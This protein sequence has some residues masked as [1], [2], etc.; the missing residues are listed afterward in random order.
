[1]SAVVVRPV[2]TRAERRAFLA[3][4]WRI[5]RDDPLWVPPLL[6]D[7]ADRIDPRKGIFFKRGEAEFF[8]AWRGGEPVVVQFAAAGQAQG[9]LYRVHRHRFVLDEAHAPAVLQA[10]VRDGQVFQAAIAGEHQIGE[11][12]GNEGRVP[13]H[14][15][16]ADAPFAPLAQ[17][18][19]CGGATVAA[20]HDDDVAGG[21][22]GRRGAARQG[23]SRGQAGGLEKIATL[24]GHGFSSRF[25][26]AR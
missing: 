12:A 3:F 11:G 22:G 7:W 25:W 1:M 15:G 13:F 23:G 9:A 16:D 8:I 26:A 14:Q 21:P 10:I 20:T 2:C 17:V 4:P 24:Q 5:F 19:G 6:P 18:L